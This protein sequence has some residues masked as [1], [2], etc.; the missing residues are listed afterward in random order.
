MFFVLW[1]LIRNLRK[2]V[3]SFTVILLKQFGLL[4]ACSGGGWAPPF[5]FGP[6]SEANTA[7]FG[8][9]GRRQ[10][11]SVRAR[12]NLLPL[13]CCEGKGYRNGR[14]Y[15]GVIGCR[16]DGRLSGSVE[17]G[18]VLS[19]PAVRCKGSPNGILYSFSCWWKHLCVC[20]FIEKDWRNNL[21]KFYLFLPLAFLSINV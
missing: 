6:A 16:N 5:V 18:N 14:Q 10:Y 12:G 15:W 8:H 3:D 2:L 4:D 17:W 1:F 11:Y 13:L 9:P 19:K 20:Y 21:K 7:I